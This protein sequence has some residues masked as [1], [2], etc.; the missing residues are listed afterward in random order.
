MLKYVL[1]HHRVVANYKNKSH[2]SLNSD[3]E[4]DQELYSLGTSPLKS[5]PQ[6]CEIKTIIPIFSDRVSEASKGSG[7]FHWNFNSHI[8][9]SKAPSLNWVL[10]CGKGLATRALM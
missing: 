5:S 1:P 9:Y 3:A 2:H 7:I 4:P 10:H 8:S 6:S